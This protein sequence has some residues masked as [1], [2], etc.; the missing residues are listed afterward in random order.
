VRLVEDAF[1]AEMLEGKI[2]SGDAILADVKDDKIVF[3]KQ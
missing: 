1:S 3:L 2:A